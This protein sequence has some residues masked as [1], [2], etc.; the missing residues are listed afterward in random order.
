MKPDNH[1]ELAF[2]AFLRARDVAALP[3]IEARRSY[4]DDDSVKSPDFLVIG[5]GDSRLVVD[6][7]GRKFG[8]TPEKPRRTWKSWCLRDDVESLE[9][10][11][12][13][14]GPGFRGVFAFVY[15][16][17]PEISLS[18]GTLDVFAF[19]DELYL[20]R[21]V[22][23]VDYRS[24]MRTF[25][26]SW[27]TVHVPPARFRAVVKPFSWFLTSMNHRGKENTEPRRIEAF[28]GSD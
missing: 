3:I 21:G 28:T 27:N 18:W 6:V 14:F 11:A 8:G 23:V 9:R 26:P 4:L 7:K 24:S 19:R 16:L 5:D 13:H 22:E 25:S 17:A 2:E 10:W 12:D 20:I 15:H 1:Y